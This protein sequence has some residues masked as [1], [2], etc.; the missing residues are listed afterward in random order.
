MKSPVRTP[1]NVGVL[2]IPV[3]LFL[4]FE[5][6]QKLNSVCSV[7]ASVCVD[8]VAIGACQHTFCRHCVQKNTRCPLCGV[9]ID[10]L[11]AAT[12]LQSA[13]LSLKVKCQSRLADGKALPL[14]GLSSFA[15]VF[16]H[17]SPQEVNSSSFFAD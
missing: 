10:S 9:S 2:G 14:L 7:C 12:E 17:A 3:A 4:D 13:V 6:L 16:G 8:P 5:A 11:R 15:S 1:L